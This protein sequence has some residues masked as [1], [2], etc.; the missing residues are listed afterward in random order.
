MNI[1]VFQF[2]IRCFLLKYEVLKI[3]LAAIK[4][5]HKCCKKNLSRFMKAIESES[6]IPHLQTF[7][8]HGTLM[9]WM[10]MPCPVP[11]CV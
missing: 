6:I 2:I 5:P 8:K 4:Q 9:V 3:G 7:A 10:V 1:H 11:A